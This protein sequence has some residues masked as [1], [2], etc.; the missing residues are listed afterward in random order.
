MARVVEAEPVL[1]EAACRLDPVDLARVCGRVV[2]HVDPDGVQ[3]DAAQDFT[4][5]GI[6]L[7]PFDGMVLVPSQ[8]DPEG[9]AALATAL[10][11]LMAPPGPCELR[12]PAQRRADALVDLA[13][14]RYAR[15]GYRRWVGFGRRS[16]S[17][18]PRRPW[19]AGPGDTQK[20]TCPYLPIWNG[21]V[22]SPARWRSA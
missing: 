16:R 15:V 1:A 5:R 21:L 13:R 2:A 20:P 3:P 14:G 12:S 9:G 18:S 10:D 4:R 6:T 17:W 7:S 11:A 8:L 22:T 19:P